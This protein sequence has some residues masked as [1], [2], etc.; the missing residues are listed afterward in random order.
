MRTPSNPS[1]FRHK[2]TVVG[3]TTGVVAVGVALGVTG[4]AS[5]QPTPTPG[6]TPSAGVTAA[7]GERGPGGH[8]RGAALAADL[9]SKLG[10]DQATVETALGEVRKANRPAK[11]TPGT[12]LTPADRAADDAAL[13]A[14]LADKLGVDEAKVKTALE[15]IRAAHQAERA[16]ALKTRLDAAVKAGTLT[17]AEA[18]AVQKA[19]DTGVIHV[20]PR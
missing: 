1:S 15:E 18:D 17:Q 2:R 11:P 3:V 10:L 8:G 16:A 4:L 5:A 20:G 14:R 19:A 13:A 6:T 12:A 9:A 7:P